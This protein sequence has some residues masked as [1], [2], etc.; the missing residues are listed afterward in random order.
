[1][2]YGHALRI[3]F[4]EKASRIHSISGGKSKQ[5]SDGQILDV[6]AW[7]KLQFL[8]PPIDLRLVRPTLRRPTDI[9]G[10]AAY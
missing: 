2:I 1:M 10:G 3:A 5:L 4:R 7:L 9:S 8:V 6:N